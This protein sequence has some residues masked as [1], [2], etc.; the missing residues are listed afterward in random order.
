MN[1]RSLYLPTVDD[2][3]LIHPLY[4]TRI[5]KKRS[6]SIG[7]L[8]CAFS[9]FKL[10]WDL[11]LR[12]FI[13]TVTLIFLRLLLISPFM[14]VYAWSTCEIRLSHYTIGICLS[15][16]RIRHWTNVSLMHTSYTITWHVFWGLFLITTHVDKTKDKKSEIIKLKDN[17]SCRCL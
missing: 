4:I 2:L 10:G 14:Y 6:R 7:N 16:P 8:E 1:E 17:T 5:F 3:I 11:M 13:S 15:G 9:S 12:F